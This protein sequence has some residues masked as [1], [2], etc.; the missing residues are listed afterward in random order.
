MATIRDSSFDPETLAAMDCARAR[1]CGALG[2]G[3]GDD[4]LASY[5]AHSIAATAHR[6]VRGA[7]AL[8]DA[9]LQQLEEEAVIGSSGEAFAPP[10]RVGD[11]LPHTGG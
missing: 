10:A 1:V 6:G 8:A 4:P 3:D 9:V 5:V 11:H 7:D 2:L